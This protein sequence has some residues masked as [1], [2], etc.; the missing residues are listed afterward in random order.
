MNNAVFGKTMENVRNRMSLH[1]T[2]NNDNAIKWFSK[3][4]LKDCKEIEGLYLIEMYKQ[5]IIYDKPIYVGTSV[6]DLSKLC[7]MDFHYNTIRS[8]MVNT[9]LYIL[10]LT[11]LFIESNILIFMN[12][13]QTINIILI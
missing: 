5:E 3:I 10:I 9:T 6:L 7:M 12:G 13:Y 4:N 11:V 8:S 1:M 2:V